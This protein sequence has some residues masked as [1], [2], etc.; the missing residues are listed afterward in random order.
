MMRKIFASVFFLFTFVGLTD[1]YGFPPGSPYPGRELNCPQVEGTELMGSAGSV[2]KMENGRLNAECGYF[3]KKTENRWSS[4]LIV[5]TTW[6]EE[7]KAEQFD[8]K[9]TDMKDPFRFRISRDT[10]AYAEVVTCDRQRYAY[11]F[12][13]LQH[14]FDQ[15]KNLALPCLGTLAPTEE[16]SIAVPGRNESPGARGKVIMTRGKDVTIQLEKG[17]PEAAEGDMVELSFS[18]GGEVIPVGKWRVSAVKENG[19]VEARP[20]KAKGEPNIGMDALIHIK[21][22]KAKKK[23]IKKEKHPKV[24]TAGGSSDKRTRYEKACDNG[25]AEACTQLGVM[26]ATGKGV[27]LNIPR[28]VEFYRKACDG[29]SAV[30]CTNLGYMYATGKGV[31]QDN[32]RAAA[33]YKRGCD[34]GNGGGC[35]NLGFMYE[36]G[37]GVDQ[38]NGLATDYYQ[39]GC[40]GGDA[41]GCS[42]LGYMYENGR[43]VRQ[44]YGR[45][46]EYYK[47]GCDGGNGR[48]CGNLGWMY[49]QGHGTVAD[50]G[51]GRKL[52]KKACKMG[53]E[54]SCNKLRELGK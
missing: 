26:Y 53:N 21:N 54:W 3:V 37:N 5:Q 7:P 13:A 51:R 44:D 20:F 10:Q 41:I 33:Y 35:T 19:T 11:S 29:G 36:N 2:F 28:A 27:A 8:C 25:D 48:G 4:A 50:Q 18:A 46:I 23:S 43:G 39:K 22:R 16:K 1:S 52:M 45:S 17:Q 42:N 9:W 24:E 34:G 49:Y 32:V 31:P 47:R 30:G 38:D 40:D 15:V 14:I 12:D 6:V